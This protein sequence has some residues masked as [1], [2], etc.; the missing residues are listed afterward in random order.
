M[1]EAEEVPTESTNMRWP[2]ALKEAVKAKA[3]ARGLTEFTLGA[4]EQRLLSEDRVRDLEK[5]VGQLRYLSQLLADRVAMGGDHEDRNHL[6]MEVELPSWMKTDGWPKDMKGLVPIVPPRVTKVYSD[7]ELSKPMTAVGAE[8]V[9]PGQ[10]AS[11]VELGGSAE[12]EVHVSTDVR[13]YADDRVIEEVVEQTP[14][15][16][17]V[18]KE[19][20]DDLF[21]RIQ[22]KAAEKGLDISGAGLVPA[23]QIPKPDPVEQVH[24]HSFER[25]DDGNLHCTD[26]ACDTWIDESTTPGTL[27]G[28]AE[29]PTEPAPKLEVQT[30]IPTPVAPPVRDLSGIEDDF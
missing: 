14:F 9:A 5:E 16:E 7:E 10:P 18:F 4:V 3:G 19:A 28:Q 25:R 8:A 13:D 23:S 11:Q 29:V 6:L 24:N 30:P 22:Q 2:I 12:P 15:A 26:A 21:S 20:G 1:T 17:A 27:H